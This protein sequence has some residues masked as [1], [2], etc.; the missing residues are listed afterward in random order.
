MLFRS[1]Q[2]DFVE[3]EYVY[4]TTHM[5]APKDKAL[6]CEQCHARTGR[7]ANLAGFYMPGRDNLKP[8][9]WLGWFGVIGSLAGVG[10]HGLARAFSRRKKEDKS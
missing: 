7:L 2:F 4:P 1:G 9:D 10:L 3:T 5:V 8:L 6:N